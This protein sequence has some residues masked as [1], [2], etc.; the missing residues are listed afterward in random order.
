MDFR[1]HSLSNSLQ[2]ELKE[3]RQNEKVDAEA[4]HQRRKKN[5]H[6]RHVCM[7]GIFIIHDARRDPA[8]DL[9]L[10]FLSA[11][12]HERSNKQNELKI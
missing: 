4:N 5:Q 3:P 1:F 9:K 2:P 12:L 10:F 11:P 6:R 7:L 8:R